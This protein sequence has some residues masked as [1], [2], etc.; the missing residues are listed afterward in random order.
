MK[1][2]HTADLHLNT[3]APET[4]DTFDTVLQTAR[5]EEIDLLTIGGDIFDS[6][7]DASRLRTD[8]RD[9]CSGL[10][11]DIVAIPGNHDADIFDQGFDLGTD[12]EVL[13][14]QPYSEV[15]IDDVSV[16]G[17]PFTR[18]MSGDLFSAL[19]TASPEQSVRILLLHCTLDLGFGRDAAGSDE[20][21]RY[22]PVE[23]ATLS[24][25]DYDF[26]LA[27][28]IHVRFESRD[29]ANGGRFVYPGSPISH[30]WTEQGPRHAALIDTDTGGVEQIELPTPYLDREEWL[31]TPGDQDGVPD[32]IAAW[33]AEHDT[34]RSTLEVIVRGYVDADEQAYNDRLREAAGDIDP[35]L[36]VESVTSVLEHDIYREVVDRFDDEHLDQ[37]DRATREGVDELLIGELAPL[38]H[39]GEVR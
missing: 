7:E 10:P 37:Y 39:A 36:D 5:E 14:E 18:R 30:S 24:E 19:K 2:L 29:L 15:T 22:F 12:L 31:V 6:P 1:I 25:L 21:V 17:V 16:V 33:V 34:A 32:D 26:V 13:R 8:V 28:H 38:L 20:E 9:L 11:F 4:L 23:P 35:T 27:G 3:D